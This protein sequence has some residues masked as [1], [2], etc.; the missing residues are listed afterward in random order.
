MY[1]NNNLTKLS[2]DASFR[3]FYRYKSKKKTILVFAEKEEKKKS[4]N[5][6][7]YK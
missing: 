1:L 4:F 3:K 6:R 5:L 2:G 7:C